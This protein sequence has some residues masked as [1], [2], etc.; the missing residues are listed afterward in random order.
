MAAPFSEVALTVI[1]V[2]M[3]GV[4]A[5]ADTP[6]PRPKP[7]IPATP[8]VIPLLPKPVVPPK[9]PLDD[10]QQLQVIQHKVDDMKQ[11]LDRIEDAL[12]EKLKEKGIDE[13]DVQGSH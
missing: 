8:V 12:D 13:R 4:V 10:K 2:L 5:L 11:S 9:P 6:L 1:V 7:D 3:V